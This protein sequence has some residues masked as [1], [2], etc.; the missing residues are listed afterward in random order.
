MFKFGNDLIAF[1]LNE[2]VARSIV[3][4]DET[5][6]RALTGSFNEALALLG[7]WGYTYDAEND[8]LS[9]AVMRTSGFM[10]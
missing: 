5:G 9:S 4:P 2:I 6:F 3:Y 7:E 1:Q 10:K 8:R